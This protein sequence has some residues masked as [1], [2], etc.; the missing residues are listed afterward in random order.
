LIFKSLVWR[1][2]LTFCIKERKKER[3]TL[4]WA[5][6]SRCCTSECLIR[7]VCHEK[8]LYALLSSKRQRVGGS[9]IGDKGYPMINDLRLGHHVLLQASAFIKVELGKN[10]KEKKKR[11][12]WVG[13]HSHYLFGILNTS[14]RKHN[15][16][17]KILVEV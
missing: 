15:Y 13:A 11:G 5:R 17:W 3:K 9:I 6:M 16:R 12:E 14:F 1:I 8:L 4:A 10:I 2:S 7:I